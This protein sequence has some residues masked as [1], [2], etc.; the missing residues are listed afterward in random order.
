MKLKAVFAPAALL[1]ALIFAGLCALRVTPAN[2]APAHLAPQQA[3]STSEAQTQNFAG[4]IVSQNGVRFILRDDQ[5][6]VWYHIDDQQQAAKF[7]G[8]VVNITGTLDG[9]T[10][11][12]RVRTITEAKA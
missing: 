12:I 8:K 10:D 7:L 3:A 1:A 4:K 9:Q 2:A 11:M 6:N 5:E